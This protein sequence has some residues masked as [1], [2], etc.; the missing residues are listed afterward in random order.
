MRHAA[1]TLTTFHVG[2]DGVK[3]SAGPLQKLAVQWLDGCWLGFN[4]RT[5]EHIVINTTGTGGRAV[6]TP[7]RHFDSKVRVRLVAVAG[8]TPCVSG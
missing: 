1:W 2:N 6:G 4:T 3:K 5:G 8:V 7:C